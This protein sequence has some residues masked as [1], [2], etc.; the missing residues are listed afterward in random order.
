LLTVHNRGSVTKPLHPLPTTIT[1]D[2]PKLGVF[3]V[4]C[5]GSPRL[6]FAENE[7]NDRHIFDTTNETTFVK[8][9]INDFPLGRTAVV[10]CTC[11]STWRSARH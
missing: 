2:H 1:A 4:K 3:Q 9:G 7:T 11:G 10:K 6:L 5:D 8:D